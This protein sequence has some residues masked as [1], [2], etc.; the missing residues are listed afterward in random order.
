METAKSITH[1]CRYCQKEFQRERSLEVH[2]CEP[3]RRY[4]EQNEAGVRLG[5]YAYSKFYEQTQ[6]SARLKT[7]DDFAESQYY[8]AFTRWG[9]Y[10]VDIRAINPEAFLAW[11]LRNNKKIDG[12]CSDKI[13]TEYLVQ[14]LPREHVQDALRRAV[15]EMQSYCDDHSDIAGIG[16]Y[17]LY[18][19]SN[20]VCYHISTGRISAWVVYNCNSGIEFLEK[21]QPE[22]TS[23]VL[24]WIDPDTWQKIFRERPADVE[25]ARHILQQAG[26]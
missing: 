17:F 19:N 14:Y 21:L 22:Q 25:W 26:L 2:L 12:W 11:L 3:K 1:Q 5:F 6:G 8:R 20:K 16:H 10:C 23:I 13:Y 4:Q 15:E 18:A 7:F 9:R 24:P